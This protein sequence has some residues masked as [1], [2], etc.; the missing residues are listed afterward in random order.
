VKTLAAE[1]ESVEQKD[2]KIRKY[3]GGSDEG[4]AAL[5]EVHRALGPGLLESA[6]DFAA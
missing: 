6:C 5:I 1:E 2:Q 4:I 3:E